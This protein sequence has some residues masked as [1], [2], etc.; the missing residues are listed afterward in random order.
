M[1]IIYLCTRAAGKNAQVTVCWQ[2]RKPS[3]E[4]RRAAMHLE[5]NAVTPC[6]SRALRF[7]Q[8]IPWQ[9]KV[10]VAAVA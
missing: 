2:S 9:V 8:S 10:Y 1:E 5:H 3:S 4:D 6:T 7:S